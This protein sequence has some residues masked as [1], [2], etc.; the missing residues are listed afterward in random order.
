MKRFFIT[1]LLS[2]GS[3][4]S[5]AQGTAA[6]QMIDKEGWTAY[7]KGT[8]PLVISVPHGGTLNLGEVADRSCEGAVTVTDSYTKELA[9]EI[10][11][12]LQKFKGQLPYLVICNLIRKDIDQNRDKSEATCGDSRME[13]P[14]E[15]FHSQID[16]AIDEAISKFGHCIYIDLHGHGHPEQR[17]ELGYMLSD[18]ELKEIYQT[19]QTPAKQHSL[20]NY[21]TASKGTLELHDLLFGPEAFGTLMAKEGFPAVPS[22]QDPFPQEGQKYFNG[23][24]NTRRYTAANRPQVVGWQIESNM[25]GVRD[26]AGRPVFAAAFAK[27]IT[28]YIE[29]VSAHKK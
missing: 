5:F 14:W 9:L 21:L 11:D 20:S 4:A 8:M 22:A 13:G 2:M 24:Y 1:V 23:G 25:K 18:K 28:Q 16:D 17:L 15:V 10:A 3:L 7:L 26:K 27:V 12:Q 29:Q 19:K 6:L